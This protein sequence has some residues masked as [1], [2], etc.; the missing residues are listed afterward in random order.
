MKQPTIFIQTFRQLW[1][2]AN[3]LI[4]KEL[5][6]TTD[7]EDNLCVLIRSLIKWETS[8]SEE[9]FPKAAIVGKEFVTNK[10]IDALLSPFSG[11]LKETQDIVNKVRGSASSYELARDI[12]KALGGDPDEEEKRAEERPKAGKPTEGKPTEGKAEGEEGADEEEK[13]AKEEAAGTRESV[14]GKEGSGEE[15]KKGEAGKSS[16]KGKDTKFG[17]DDEDWCIKD[18]VIT[19]LDKLLPTVHPMRPEMSKVGLNYKTDSDIAGWTLTPWEN[20]YVVNYDKNTSY[21][22]ERFLRASSP[23]F[24]KHFETRVKDKAQASENFSQQVRRLI[25][26][27]TRSKYE[28]GVKKGKLDQARLARIALRQPGFSERVFKNKIN[29]LVLDASCTILVDMS[30]S[31]T[32]DKVLFACEAVFLLNKVFKAIDVPLEILG[33]TDWGEHP[34]MYVYKSFSTPKIEDSQLIEYFSKS[35]TYMTGNPDGDAILWAHNRLVKRREKKRLLIVMSDGQPAA[36]R[37]QIGLGHFTKAVI[38]EIEKQKYVDI[39]GLGLSSECVTE[40]YKNHSVVKS[41]EQIPVQLLQLLERKLI[42]V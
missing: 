8:A 7:K 9:V 3:P 25:Q 27:R 41:P 33:F 4:L 38:T 26:I 1:D 2:D 6:V 15:G 42:N 13:R 29:N 21:G 24:I 16:T 37:S 17:L 34:L 36:S 28:Y 35:S 32:G 10:D 23:S 40:Y 12:F 5:L 11:R 19:G 14:K 39:Y 30:G 20:F 18:I 22:G 31:M